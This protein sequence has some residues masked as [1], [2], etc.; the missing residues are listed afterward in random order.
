MGTTQFP[1]KKD[2]EKEEEEEEEVGLGPTFYKKS[3]PNQM[4]VCHKLIL[5]F[6]YSNIWTLHLF[7]TLIC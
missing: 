2:E 3:L 5:L 6:T 1:T 4:F 7:R